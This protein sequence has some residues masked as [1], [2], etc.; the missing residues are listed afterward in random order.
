MRNI[1]IIAKY[2]YLADGTKVSAMTGDDSGFSYRG[3]FTY[4]TDAE[5]NRVFESTPFSGGRIVAT[6]GN[7]TVVRYFLTDHLGSVRV[8]ATDQNNV[9]ERNDYQP[10][11][12]RW[13]T[14]SMPVSD[15]RHRFNGKEDQAFAGLPFSDYG[16]RMYDRERGRWISQD[17]LAEEYRSISQY[18]YCADNPV[19]AIDLQGKLIIFINGFTKDQLQ[20]GTREYWQETIDGQEID[21]AQ[22]TMEQLNDNN[23]L[24]RHGGTTEESCES[25]SLFSF[26]APPARHPMRLHDPA[27]GYRYARRILRR[28]LRTPRH[29]SALTPGRSADAGA[30]AADTTSFPP[31][32]LH[33]QTRRRELST[34][35][36]G[37]HPERHDA[38]NRSQSKTAYSSGKKPTPTPCFFIFRF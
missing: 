28:E 25:D 11:G 38:G 34:G 29:P 15:N 19:S 2:S 27:A 18:G 8:V 17:P 5:A 10:F 16:A 1:T 20:Q 30:N 3:S 36:I 14:P 22:A 13:V 26:E 31:H 35:K 6:S 7:D 21:F 24:Y 12:K 4:R 32:K 33:H 37:R 9:I 23:A